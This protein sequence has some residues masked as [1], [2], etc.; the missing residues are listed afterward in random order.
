[1]S[2]ILP[3]KTPPSVAEPPRIQSSSKLGFL[4]LLKECQA[5]AEGKFISV[6]ISRSSASAVAEMVFELP[7]VTIR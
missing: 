6:P 5:P 4:P 3:A 2:V 1:M 7:G